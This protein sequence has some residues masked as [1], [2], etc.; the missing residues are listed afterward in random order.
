MNVFGKI[1]TGLWLAGAV[2]ATGADMPKREIRAVWL[3]TIYGL[4]WPTRPA[5][6][7]AG[8]IRQQE[9]LCLLL[10]RLKAANFNTVFVQT[11]LRGDV[12]YHSAIEPASNVFSGQYG[13][14]PGYDPLAFVID[15]CH[16]RGLECHAFL[17]TF[18]VGSPKVVR[19]QGAQSVVRKHPELCLQHNG[20]WYMDPG[21]PG[22]CDY[23]LALVGEIVEHYDVDGIQFD[24]VRYPENAQFFPDRQTFALYGDGKNLADW[25]RGNI[26]RLME[27]VYDWVRQ[28]K[29]WVQVSSSPLGKYRR[30]MQMPDAGWTAFDDVYQDPKAWLQAGKQDMIVPMMYY[31]ENDFYPF[32][33]I[34]LEQVEQRNMVA[35]LGAYRLNREEGDWSLAEMVDQINYVRRQGG[36]GCAFFRAR[37]VTG[38]EKGLYRELKNHLFRFPAQLPPL[39]WLADT[40]PPEAP[41]EMTVTREDDYLRL[42]WED[43]SPPGENTYTVYYSLADTLDTDQARSILATG[44]RGREICLPVNI[45]TEKGYLFCVTA[46]NRYRIESRPS[47]ETYY[48]LSAFEK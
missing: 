45:D 5:T 43:A 29:P 3:T 6:D 14:L 17:V 10:D 11:R 19:E 42:A 36:D 4:D 20:N 47:Y 27:R 46:S 7:E 34:W 24:Y 13:V 41:P 9:E 22:T 38:D 2:Y 40:L 37:F 28:T 8:R 25:R 16:R 1:I 30:D 15:E 12:I 33:N 32:V 21:R 23:I 48:Y 18:P 44:I 39:T 26:N 31:R 35:G